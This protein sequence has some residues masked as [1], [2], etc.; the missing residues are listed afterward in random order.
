MAHL[1]EQVVLLSL[2][3]MQTAD[4]AEWSRKVIFCDLGRQLFLSFYVLSLVLERI[5]P[6]TTRCSQSKLDIER[7]FPTLNL[8]II[9]APVPCDVIADNI[10]SINS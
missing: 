9:L 10:R 7:V 1:E 5:M 8:A 3:M 4:F 2:P 6:F